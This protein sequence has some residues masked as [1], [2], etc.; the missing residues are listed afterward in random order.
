MTLLDVEFVIL[1]ESVI[2]TNLFCLETLQNV[3]VVRPSRCPV[4]A[5]VQIRT[6]RLDEGR[7]ALVEKCVKIRRDGLALLRR[8]KRL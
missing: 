8:V 3:S 2:T 7:L 1:R 6:R 5:I 4:N